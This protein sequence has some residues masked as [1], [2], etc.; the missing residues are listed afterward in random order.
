MILT[1]NGPVY[2]ETNTLPGL[3]RPSFFPQQLNVADLKFSDF[4]HRQLELAEKR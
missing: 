2:L 3:S 1:A 4:I